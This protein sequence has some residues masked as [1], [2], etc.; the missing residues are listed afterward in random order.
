MIIVYV[1]S[2]IFIYNLFPNNN[3]MKPCTANEIPSSAEKCHRLTVEVLTLL[4]IHLCDL[5][6]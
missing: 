1:S 5:S 6:I 2:M 4:L 3:S